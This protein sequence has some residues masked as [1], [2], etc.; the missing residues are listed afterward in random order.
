MLHYIIVM[1]FCNNKFCICGNST[2][3]KL[4]IIWV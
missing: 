3:H 1:V 4:I 2:I